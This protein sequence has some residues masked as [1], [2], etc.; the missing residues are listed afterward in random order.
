MSPAL[1]EVSPQLLIDI[2]LTVTPKFSDIVS[3]SDDSLFNHV[4][5]NNKHTLLANL[6]PER[7]QYEYSVRLRRHDRT[8]SDVFTSFRRVLK[9]T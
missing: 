1:G 2:R 7:V 3:D 4:L 8:L 5:Y 6:L 9:Q